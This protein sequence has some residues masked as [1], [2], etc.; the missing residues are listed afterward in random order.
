MGREIRHVIPNWDHP[1]KTEYNVFRRQEETFYQPMYDRSYREAAETWRKKFAEW[2]ASERQKYFQETGEDYEYW[3]WNGQPPDKNYYRPDWKPDEVTWIQV[4][5]TVSEGTPVSPPFAT[6]EELID[7]LVENGDFW[8]QKRGDGGWTRENATAF[9]GRGFAMSMM[10]N[11][12][13]GEIKT[14]RDGA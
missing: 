7:Y 8:D 10:V 2:E 4:Y 3:D 1:M 9:V 6:R 14:A 12:A 5:E 13:T 11:T